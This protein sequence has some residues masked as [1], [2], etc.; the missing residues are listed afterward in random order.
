MCRHTH[1]AFFT[2]LMSFA[3]GCA[4]AVVLD[5]PEHWPAE[6]AQRRLYHT[7]DAYIYA[8]SGAAAGEADRLVRSVGRRFERVTGRAAPKCLL[9]VTDTHDEPPVDGIDALFEMAEALGGDPGRNAEVADARP[10]WPEQRAQAQESGLDLNLLIAAMPVP[11][12]RE[13]LIQ[14]LGFPAGPA[15]TV[16]AALI[17]PT[18]GA[19]RRF[20]HTTLEAALRQEEIGLAER[21]LFAPLLPMVEGKVVE[22]MSRARDRVLIERFVEAQTDWDEETRRA[23]MALFAFPESAPPHVVELKADASVSR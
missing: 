1:S 8:S 7:P 12:T 5:A 18:R 6:Q 15:A 23:K 10:D 19:I 16:E 9:F 21:L 17:I 22:E 14:T 11:L 3:A 20:I 2:I 4:P 13:Q